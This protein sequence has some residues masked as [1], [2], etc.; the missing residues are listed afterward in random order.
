MIRPDVETDIEEHPRH[1]GLM[2]IHPKSQMQINVAMR[3]STLLVSLEIQ[4][5]SYARSHKLLKP[6]EQH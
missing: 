3:C 6:I 4:N 5:Q 2:S 1:S